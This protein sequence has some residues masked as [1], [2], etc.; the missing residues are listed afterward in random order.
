MNKG[1]S[2][3]FYKYSR[4]TLLVSTRSVYYTWLMSRDLCV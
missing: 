2:F 3:T 1:V 4:G